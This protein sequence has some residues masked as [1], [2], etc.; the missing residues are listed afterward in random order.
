M[1]LKGTSYAGS[2]QNLNS[3]TQDQRI[4]GWYYNYIFIQSQE[5]YL[6]SLLYLWFYVLSSRLIPLTETDFRTHIKYYDNYD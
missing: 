4:S 3:S 2:L 5:R 1:A 6:I